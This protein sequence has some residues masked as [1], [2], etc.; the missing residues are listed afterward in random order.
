MNLIFEHF[1]STVNEVLERTRS[2]AFYSRASLRQRDCFLNSKRVTKKKGGFAYGL[3]DYRLSPVNVQNVRR[4]S[5]ET[6]P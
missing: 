3:T 4:V 1:H 2:E 5:L 6:L